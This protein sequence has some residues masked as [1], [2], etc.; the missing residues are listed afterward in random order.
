VDVPECARG[1]TIAIQ[2][3]MSFAAFTPPRRWVDDLASKPGAR[4]PT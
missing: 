1:F 4:V 2:V 3:R